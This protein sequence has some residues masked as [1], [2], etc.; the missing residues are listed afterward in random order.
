M[1]APPVDS[2]IPVKIRGMEASY[3]ANPLSHTIE[4][5]PWKTVASHAAAVCVAFL[6]IM[7]GVY[8]AVDPFKFASLAKNLLVPH[9]L[10]LPLALTL[11]VAET[12]AGVLI[13]VPRF[14]RWGAMLAGLLLL[15]FMGYIGWKYKALIGRDCGCFPKLQLPFGL[16]IDMHRSVGPGFFYGDFAFLSAAAIGGIWAR[17]SAGLRTAVVILGAV[18]VFTG[19]SYGVAVNHQTGLKAPDSI[20]VDGQPM[21]LQDGRVFLFFFDPE[22]GTCNAVGKSMG[23]LKFHSDVTFVGVP[24]RRPEAG[25]GFMEYN[26]L[27]GKLAIENGPNHE[28]LASTKLRE[29]FKFDNPPYAALIESGRQTGVIMP[30]QFDEDDSSKHIALLRQMGVID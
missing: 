15:A 21:S 25:K 13:L 26:G 18:A 22:C 11:A 6:F 4:M 1:V 7:A 20:M 28:N 17:R 9:N 24:T 2:P 10:A 3:T 8:K 23:P 5:P 14:R 29:V 30:S 19:V 12:T 16:T 27:K